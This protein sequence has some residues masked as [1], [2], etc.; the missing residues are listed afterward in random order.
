[1]ENEDGSPVVVYIRPLTVADEKGLG[2]AF[3]A[4]KDHYPE[5][6]IKVT[7]LTADGPEKAFDATDVHVLASSVPEYILTKIVDTAYT[8]VSYEEAEKNFG[9]M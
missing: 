1:M 7:Y 5:L 6:V 8:A 4:G 3:L 2:G 9:K